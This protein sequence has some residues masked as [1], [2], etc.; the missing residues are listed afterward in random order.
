MHVA[1]AQREIRS[2]YLGGS[3]GTLVSGVIWIISAALGTWVSISS[4][5]FG[6]VIGGMFIFPVTMLALKAMARPRS[7]SP[8]RSPIPSSVRR[9]CTTSIGSI[10]P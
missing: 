9:P 10:P 5:I 4:A 6:L 7:R 1:D 2:V 8:S 3:V